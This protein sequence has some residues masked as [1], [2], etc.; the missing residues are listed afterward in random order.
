MITIRPIQHS[1]AEIDAVAAILVAGFADRSPAWPTLEAGINE[2]NAFST[3]E[4]ISLVA[5]IND[6]IV[7]WI[8]AT[9]QYQRFGW[10]LHPL[11]VAPAYQHQGIGKALV[12]ALCA[13]L[14]EHG[15]TTVFAWSDDESLSTSLGGK[16]LFLN[17]LEHLHNFSSSVRH[18]GGF[19]LKQGFVLC[20]VLPDANGLGKPDILFARRIS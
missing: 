7:G 8:S 3:D 9:P 17:P 15:A 10:E 1:R 16:D 18:A 4:H 14:A 11:V 19:Y 2:V 12:A 6:T 5:T 13:R 20:G